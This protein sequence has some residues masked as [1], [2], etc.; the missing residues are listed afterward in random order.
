MG[1]ALVLESRLWQVSV[2][3]DD[4]VEVQELID[5]LRSGLAWLEEP[6]TWRMATRQAKSLATRTDIRQPLEKSD[7]ALTP[8]ELK[9][10]FDGALDAILIAD[11]EGS[12]VEANPAASALFGMRREEILGKNVGDFCPPGFDF[13]AAWSEFLRVGESRGE[14]LLKF[15]GGRARTVEYVAKASIAP[16]RH[17]SILRDVTERVEAQA[18]L[19]RRQEDLRDFVDNAPVGLHWVGE[20]G[21]VIWVN[22]AELDMLGY[23]REEYVGRH[24]SEFHADSDVIEDILGRLAA[25]E[26]LKQYDARL[27]C[28]D[29]SIRQVLISSNVKW[30]NGRFAHTRCFTRDVTDRRKSQEA[31]LEAQRQLSLAL[32]AARMGTWSWNVKTGSLDWSDNLEEI[33]G[34]APGTFQGTYQSFLDAVHPEDREM[35]DDGVRRAVAESSTY[36]A[37]FR[38]RSPEGGTRWVAGHGQVFVDAEGNPARMIGIGRDVT[39]T[40]RAAENLAKAYEEAQEAL[41]IRDAFLSIAGH[42]LR[43]PLGALGLTL[44]NLARRLGQSPDEATA[45]AVQTLQRQVDRLTR[46]TEDLLEVGQIRAGKLVLQPEPMDLAA[47]AEGVVDRF[48]DAALAAGSTLEL[49]SSGSVAGNWDS[50]RLDQVVTNLLSNALK[51]GQGKPIEIQVSRDGKR[52]VV[53]IRDEGIGISREDQARIFERFERGS[54]G[55]SYPG[56]GLGLWIAGQIIDG[57]GG[58][59]RVESEAG[60]GATFVV[61]LPGAG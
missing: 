17:L 18:E 58:R 53:S 28:K 9:A 38:V 56:L 7:D 50:S 5:D 45:R 27:R 42:E 48:R 10:I 57:H 30:E 44:H 39:E 12:Y 54:A 51:F 8:A 15:P 13:A 46:L 52:A 19:L 36:D 47:V 25:G 31:V 23:T 37:E 4:P 3:L 26:V 55:A 33:H 16:G 34:M 22:Q 24:I 2:L 6:P 60:R 49:T 21:R 35:V 20:D 59:I 32:S 41:K 1:R 29:G 40:R 14:F 11:D 43:T 61:E